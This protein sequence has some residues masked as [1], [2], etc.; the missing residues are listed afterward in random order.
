[1]NDLPVGSD[2]SLNRFDQVEAI[3][4]LYPNIN[5]VELQ[6]LK[7]WFGKEA[8]A[9]EAASLASKDSCKEGYLR[10]RAD[11]L[12]RLTTREWMIVGVVSA[13][14]L[15]SVIAYVLFAS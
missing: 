5:E 14:L 8:S 3:L 13:I 9:F 4:V 2:A 10:F 1:M 7:R 11:H 12:D 15:C 6:L